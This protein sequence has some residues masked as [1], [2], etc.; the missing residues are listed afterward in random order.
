MI[1]RKWLLSEAVQLSI[2]LIQSSGKTHSI[3]VDLNISAKV[4]L[5]TALSMGPNKL[6]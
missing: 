4:N 5:N 1:Q 2:D 3:T 6:L